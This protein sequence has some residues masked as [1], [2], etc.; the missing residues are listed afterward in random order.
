MAW[1]EKASQDNEQ[2]SLGITTPHGRVLVRQIAGLVARR[3][4][5]T[6]QNEG[7]VVQRGERIG[8]I[9]FGS[10]VDLFLPLEWEVTCSGRRD[11]CRVWARLRWLAKLPV[12]S[13]RHE[14]TARP[15]SRRDALQRGGHHPAIRIHARESLLRRSTAMVAA[16]RG[17]FIWAGWYIVFAG[18]LDMLDGRIA[19]LTRTGSR[20]GAELD[21]LVDAISFGVAPAFIMFQLYFNDT[22][23]SWIVSFV[24]VTA[25]V[26]RLARFNIEQG[27]EAKRYFHGLPSPAAGMLGGDVLPVDADGLLRPVLQRPP[28]AADHGRRHDPAGRPDGEPRSRT[29]SFP[30][31]RPADA[32]RGSRTRSSSSA[33]LFAALSIPRHFLFSFGLLYVTWGAAQVRDPRTSRSASGW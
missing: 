1:L 24:F 12:P 13:S 4:I 25:V 29:R 7:D 19:R 20:F 22:Q 21:S 26:V 9:R 30:E 8:L 28:V 15:P 18:T 17:D 10:R 5:V 23:W 11:K 6:D 2:A 14:G 27:G 3:R 32:A 16:A 31:D 33:C